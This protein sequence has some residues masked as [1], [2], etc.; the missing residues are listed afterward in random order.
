MLTWTILWVSDI[1]PEP[2]FLDL[3]FCLCLISALFIFSVSFSVH[4]Q[5]SE[6]VRTHLWVRETLFWY[7]SDSWKTWLIC[8]Q[9]QSGYLKRDNQKLIQKLFLMRNIDTDIC[10]ICKM[11]LF[12]YYYRIHDKKVVTL[13]TCQ[14]FLAAVQNWVNEALVNIL[15]VHWGV[16]KNLLAD[17]LWERNQLLTHQH[18]VPPVPLPALQTPAFTYPPSRSSKLG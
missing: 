2:M 4:C 15:T 17:A 16:S 12:I 9:T 18:N 7:G 13:K 14:I 10:V 5:S 8:F 3:T 6:A 1:L 11:L